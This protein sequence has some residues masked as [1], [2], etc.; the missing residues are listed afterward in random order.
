MKKVI[1]FLMMLIACLCFCTP[2][3]AEE[4]DD[5]STQVEVETTVDASQPRLM[6]S[7]YKLSSNRV[8]PDETANLEITLKNYSNTKAVRNVK[9]SVSDETGDIKVSG[10]PTEYVN[11]VYA[12]STYTWKLEVTASKTASVGEHILSL[13]AEYEDKYYNAYSSQDEISVTV[14]QTS[15]LDYN[16]IELPVKVTQGDTQTVSVT[17]MN[18]G[19]T[20]LRNCKVDFNVD[21][22]ES[23]GT[24]FVGEIASG[25]SKDG[26]INLRVGSDI[27]GEVSGTA[28]VSYEDEL[29]EVYTEDVELSS[30][31]EEKVETVTQSEEEEEQSKYPLW[32][33]F[34]IVGVI[35]GGLT[36]FLIPT[37]IRSRKQRKEDELRL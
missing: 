3:F 16:G 5:G 34:L 33:L 32:W 22:F 10:M 24:L 6:V 18:T 25:E 14:S 23:A 36:G 35:A 17:L 20:M 28:T 37:A 4:S 2:V 9:L 31:I 12:G 13:T 29:G 11:A 15:S 7:S 19:K 1:A 21:G 27:V 26:S 8:T 30:L